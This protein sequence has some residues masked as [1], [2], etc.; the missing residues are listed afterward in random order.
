MEQICKNCK[1]WAYEKETD[2]FGECT[3]T[4]HVLTNSKFGCVN[5]TLKAKECPFCGSEKLS[6]DREYY[7]SKKYIITCKDCRA[8]VVGYDDE[9]STITKWNTRI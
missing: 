9:R 3:N 2:E 8:S 4:L 7:I 5:W 1:Y 6:I